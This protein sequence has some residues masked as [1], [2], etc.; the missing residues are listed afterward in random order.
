MTA[1]HDNEQRTIRRHTRN[2]MLVQQR[3]TNLAPR[4]EIN[5]HNR[6]IDSRRAV[7]IDIFN[8]SAMA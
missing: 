4:F 8:L 1:I 6:V 3:A 2:Q 7:S 5:W